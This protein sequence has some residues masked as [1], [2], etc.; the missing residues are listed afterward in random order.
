MSNIYAD[1]TYTPRQADGLSNIYADQTY[2]PRPDGNGTRG[3]VARDTVPATDGAE[4]FQVT[5]VPSDTSE[6]ESVYLQVGGA[7]WCSLF[8]PVLCT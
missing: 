4:R 1:Q 5:L 3:G 2:T 7:L 8:A 6:P